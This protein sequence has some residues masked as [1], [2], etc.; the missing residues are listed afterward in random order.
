MGEA[1]EG[2]IPQEYYKGMYQLLGGESGEDGVLPMCYCLGERMFSTTHAIHELEVTWN[3]SDKEITRVIGKMV[4][5]GLITPESH[6]PRVPIGGVTR[7]NS[8]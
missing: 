6:I 4:L 7:M 3:S 5:F 1:R 8:K 2:E